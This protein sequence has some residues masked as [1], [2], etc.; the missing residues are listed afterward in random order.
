M[1]YKLTHD[2]CASAVVA[3]G[4][5]FCRVT[6]HDQTKNFWGQPCLHP[7]V[8]KNP[9][10]EIYPITMQHR[11]TKLDIDSSGPDRQNASFTPSQ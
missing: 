11:V 9:N 8:A 5:K 7:K 1:F 2:L 3:R 6:Y 4:S 10:F